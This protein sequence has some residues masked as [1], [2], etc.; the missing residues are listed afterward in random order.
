MNKGRVRES[1]SLSR[2]VCP[3]GDW[4]VLSVSHGIYGVDQSYL[5]RWSCSGY[6][7]VNPGVCSQIGLVCWCCSLLTIRVK[8]EAWSPF[9][10]LYLSV[11]AGLACTLSTAPKQL[12][13]LALIESKDDNKLKGS[14]FSPGRNKQMTKPPKKSSLETRAP[15][16]SESCNLCWQWY[17]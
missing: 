15:G 8:L 14:V 10:S 11:L 6:V 2:S 16:N 9:Y 17:R 13:V 5:C 3:V 7:I 4:G 12:S 1:E